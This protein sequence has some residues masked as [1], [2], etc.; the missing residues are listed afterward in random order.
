M[1]CEFMNHI[2]THKILI[3]GSD[4]NAQIGKSEIIMLIYVVKQMANI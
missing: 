2:P 4:R 1:W 3:I